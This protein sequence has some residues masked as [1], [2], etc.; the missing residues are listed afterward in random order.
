MTENTQK[1]D[2]NTLF[3]NYLKVILF[4]YAP[5]RRAGVRHILREIIKK[6]EQ[7]NNYIF[8][9]I[10]VKKEIAEKTGHSLT[11]INDSIIYLH[12]QGFLLKKD[13]GVYMVNKDIF[14][15]YERFLDDTKEEPIT[16][17]LK[18]NKIIIV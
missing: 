6:E 12:K 16:L 11:Y 13:R 15:H 14:K 17:I 18:N 5:K 9:N 1:T 7:G 10:N 2:E 4:V 8:L 3:D